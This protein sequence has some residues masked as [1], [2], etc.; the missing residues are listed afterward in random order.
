MGTPLPKTSNP[1]QRALEHA[2]IT[3]VE[4]LARATEHEVLD[5]HGMGPKAVRILKEALAERGLSFRDPG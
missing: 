5:L 3:T 4:Q 1:A 2:G